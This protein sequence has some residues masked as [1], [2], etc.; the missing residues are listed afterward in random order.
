MSDNVS[1]A[2][3]YKKKWLKCGIKGATK[4]VVRR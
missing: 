3:G 4:M 1:V 2:C